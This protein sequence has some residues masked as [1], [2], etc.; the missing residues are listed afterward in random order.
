M[1]APRTSHLPNLLLDPSPDTT[2]KVLPTVITM[3]LAVV[4]LIVSMFILTN[5]SKLPLANPPAW[6]QPM[7]V[8]RIEF[9]KSGPSVLDMARKS[10]GK[11]PYRLINHIGEIIVLP[12]SY[13]NTI[14][15]EPRLN[16]GE[17]LNYELPNRLSAFD[18]LCILSHE[19]K[20][21]QTV[22]K[23]QLTKFLKWKEITVSDSVL[24]LVTRL[25]SKVFLGDELCR[26]EEWL[27]LSKEYTVCSF[28]VAKKMNCIPSILKPV[29]GLFSKEV[30]I[31]EQK[32][33][34]ARA[35]LKP[36]VAER[37]RLKLEAAKK[38][39][40]ALRYNDALEWID[41][42]SQSTADTAVFQM[43][44]S[45]AAIHTTSDLL[46]QTMTR[47]AND[48]SL[49]EDLRKE[50]VQVISTDGL[51][52]LALANLKLMD[53]T[54]KET[55]RI[56]PNTIFGMRR[57][58]KE[59]VVLPDGTVIPKG[60]YVAVDIANLFDPELY[61]E[62]NKFDPY[63]YYRMRKDP[64]LAMKAHLVSTGAENISFG[65]GLH[66]C[67]G[68]FFSANEMK[69]ALC[70]LLLI[71]DWTLAAGASLEPV[72]LFADTIALDPRNKL[73]YIRREEELKLESLGFDE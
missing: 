25:S 56:N 8:K 3:S 7:L 45:F 37:N 10:Y 15:N 57:M 18:P 46:G 1:S 22:V 9:M 12:P 58:A 36:I 26:N 71:Y 54:M 32:L 42:E 5:R 35:L 29:Y 13:A 52:K 65:H 33:N 30:K 43:S 14:R 73:R 23:K 69:I 11:Q 34:Q 17:A 64:S 55:Q 19:K 27:R 21:L 48:P 39:E 20:I 47:I 38:S 53:S 68:R 31:V 50:I 44:L 24:S 66:A 59:K 51:T 72:H 62:P 49:A 61:P 6:F 41:E 2:E 16:F 70:H 63:R 28:Q 40:P 4:T 60:Q 67:P